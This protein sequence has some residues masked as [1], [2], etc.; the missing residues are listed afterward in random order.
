MLVMSPKASLLDEE[1][2]LGVRGMGP[3]GSQDWLRS[4]ERPQVRRP[5]SFLE[6]GGWRG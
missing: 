4:L 5:I 1:T 6:V 2:E 3:R